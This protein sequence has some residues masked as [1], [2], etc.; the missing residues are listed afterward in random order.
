VVLPLLHYPKFKDKSAHREMKSKGLGT[1]STSN[2]QGV[3][4]LDRTFLPK[5]HLLTFKTKEYKV[6][7]MMLA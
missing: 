4:N 2:E 6:L 7:I 5:I 1:V 3:K